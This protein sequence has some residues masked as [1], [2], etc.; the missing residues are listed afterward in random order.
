MLRELFAN[1]RRILTAHEE[2]EFTAHEE[3]KFIEVEG[4][5]YTAS[6]VLVMK[7]ALE[8]AASHRH[9][10]TYDLLRLASRYL[11]PEL[12]V[13]GQKFECLANLTGTP[14]FQA[15]FILDSLHRTKCIQGDICEYGVA[16]GRTSALIAATLNQSGSDKRLWL[17]DSFE[18]LPKPSTK[19]A[20]LHDLYGLG[21][22]ARYEGMFSIPEDFVQAELDRSGFPRDRVTICKG[23]I[24]AVTLP[25]RS[26]PMISFAYLDMDFY[27]STK[28]V[29]SL[30]IERMSVGGIAI[31]D[32]YE[33][34][35][36]G[37]KTAVDEITSE[38]PG[39]FKLE[40]PF[41]DKFAVLTRC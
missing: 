21:D 27:Q 23:W 25:T 2:K 29:L 26:P 39:A 35:S 9:R 33:F 36:S 32:D 7:R 30:L 1:L 22:M 8:D 6:Q 31:V 10:T 41:D 18:G 3:E 37:V 11:F 5:R 13:S 28:D 20:L 38:F 19:D 14:A 16:Q 24:E 15:L 40:R 17:Y 12:E 4:I 34:F